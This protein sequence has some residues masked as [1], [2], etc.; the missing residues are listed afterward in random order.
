MK[1]YLFYSILTMMVLWSSTS[2]AGNDPYN[3]CTQSKAGIAGFTFLKIIPT[4]RIAGMGNSFVAITDDI[5]SIFTN[6]A[7][8]G[9]LKEKYSFHFSN[10]KWFV[11]S[12]YYAGAFAMHLG[13][14]NYLGITAV[15]LVPE[16]T[17]ERNTAVSDPAGLTG[18]YIDMYDYAIGLNYAAK[19]FNRLSIGIKLNYVNEKIMYL[20]TSNLL[21]D[22]GS[23]FYTNFKTL[24]IGMAMRN[25]GSDAQ[26]PNRIL[27]HMPIIYTIG[28][29][30]EVYGLE[31][32]SPVKIT[33]SGEATY[34]V[35]YGQRFQL[36]AEIWLMNVLALRGGYMF[37]AGTKDPWGRFD[38]NGNQYSIGIGG[39]VKYISFDF[40]Y[41]KS[42]RLFENPMRFSLSGYF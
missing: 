42:D 35:D 16:K 26:Y 37:N 19:V 17:L 2:F 28:I 27:F 25:F 6:P 41:T 11:N 1:K 22:I 18:K 36:G 33:L 7:G 3:E 21:F 34:Q 14:I 13:G 15:G 23:I 29:A 30:G 40:S 20:S 9:M 12:N 32:K 31:E 24:R 5:N 39:K 4:A 38:Y 10:T 8:I